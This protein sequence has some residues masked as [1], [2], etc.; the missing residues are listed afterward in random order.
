[1][2]ICSIVMTLDSDSWFWF[3]VT[4]LGY[5]SWLR[6]LVMIL[7]YDSWLWFL[8]MIMFNLKKSWLWNLFNIQWLW[9]FK[10]ILA[11][12]NAGLRALGREP[13][14]LSRTESYIGVMIDDLTTQGA[15]EPY[16]MFTSRAEFRIYLRPDNADL[17]L[18]AKGSFGSE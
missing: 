15:I 9:F 16:R 5:D 17:R 11:G 7:G 12:I 1:M 2:K 4:I 18:T 10:G 6:F 14:T 8:V 3:L 13:F